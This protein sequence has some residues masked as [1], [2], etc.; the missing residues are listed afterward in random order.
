M[1][2]SSVYWGWAMPK[3]GTQ[4]VRR[5]GVVGPLPRDEALA[6]LADAVGRLPVKY[7]GGKRQLL[8]DVVCIDIH[9]V[10]AA[11]SRGKRRLTER[12]II[13]GGVDAD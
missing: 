2:L 12:G 11:I 13:L 7:E 3:R 8:A 6:L 9:S 10:G 4:N 5:Q 1:R